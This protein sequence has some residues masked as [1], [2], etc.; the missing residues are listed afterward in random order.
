MRL[1]YS[2]TCRVCGVGLPAGE[3][4][5]YERA[6]KTVR[7]ATHETDAAV[8]EADQAA[9]GGSSDALADVTDVAKRQGGIGSGAAGASARREFDRRKAAREKRVRAAHPKLGGFILAVTEEPQST[10][11][12]EVGAEGEEK[13]GRGLDARVGDSLRVLHDRRIPGTRANVDHIAVAGSGVF[14]IDAKR[15]TGRPHLKAEGG[16][17]SPRRERLLVG[18]RDCTKLVDGVLKQMDVVRGVIG[19]EVPLHGVLCFVEADWP[20]LGGA[21]TTRGVQAL[22]PK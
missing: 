4:A 8:V 17:F 2:G 6:S 3:P 14:V 16:L 10:R 7:C 1:R 15:Y 18:S 20:L 9:P 13:L 21:F 11:A 5:I 22:W 12:W 19:E